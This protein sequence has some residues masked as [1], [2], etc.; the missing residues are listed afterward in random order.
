MLKIRKFQKGDELAL[1][2]LKY[3]TIRKINTR[4]Y[5]E[6]QTFAW[7]PDVFD[8]EN[9]AKKIKT[10]NPFVAEIDGNIVGYAD[11]QIDGYIDHF[12]CHFDYQGQGVGKA[13]M[14]AIFKNG[15]AKGIERFYSHVSI[16]ASPFFEHF[17]FVVIKQQSVDIRGQ[18]LTNFVMEKFI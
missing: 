10:M 6:E 14:Q 15:Q 4:D 9:W 2:K 18:V 11:I 12:F 16:T 13:L 3:D 8:A 17:G 5:T 1:W 7:A